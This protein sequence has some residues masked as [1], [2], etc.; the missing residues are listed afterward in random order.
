[1]RMHDFFTEIFTIAFTY[2]VCK[3]L[4]VLNSSNVDEILWSS[5]RGVLSHYSNMQTGFR[6]DPD[7]D[8]G[9]FDGILS[10]LAEFCTH[11]VLPVQFC[12]QMHENSWTNAANVRYKVKERRGKLKER[13]GKDETSEPCPTKILSRCMVIRAC[14]EA[15]CAIN[16][17]WTRVTLCSGCDSVDLLMNMRGAP[18]RWAWLL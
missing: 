13:Q 15:S 7:P 16:R 10:I 4:R 12:S 11:W 17:L 18:R 8:P 14:V 5:S 1:M 6:A 2:S 3:I 9:I